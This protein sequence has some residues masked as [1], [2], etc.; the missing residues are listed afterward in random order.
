MLLFFFFI[1]RLGFQ[2]MCGSDTPYV[3]FFFYAVFPTSER[4]V[5]F[6]TERKYLIL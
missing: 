5:Y 2:L 1:K 6:H 4:H 3:G